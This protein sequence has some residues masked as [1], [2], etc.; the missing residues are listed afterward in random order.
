MICWSLVGLARVTHVQI[1]MTPDLT[2]F[3]SWYGLWIGGS[4][5]S[6]LSLDTSWRVYHLMV[7]IRSK[8]VVDGQYLCQIL[9][10]FIFLN[11]MGGGSYA[12]Q[13]WWIWF[14]LVL[15]HLL[16]TA[17]VQIL[18]PMGRKAD[19]IVDDNWVLAIGV[20]RWFDTFGIGQQ[21]GGTSWSISNLYNLS[22]FPTHF[23]YRDHAWCGMKTLT[24]MR[25]PM[26]I[27]MK[28][29]WA[30]PPKLRF[31]MTCMKINVIFLG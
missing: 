15:H 6:P 18:M 3:G 13:S 10:S 28:K 9:G 25:S 4:N 7:T 29:L 17:R 16:S 22:R 5:T 1:F 27:N 26:Q 19:D 21:G 23:G 20:Q 12:H 11:A 8:V 24:L 30:S 2:S 31:H 14:N